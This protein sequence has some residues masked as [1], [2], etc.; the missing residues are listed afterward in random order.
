MNCSSGMIISK[1]PNTR[2]IEWDYQ[3][4]WRKKADALGMEAFLPVARW[5]A[6][7]ARSTTSA[8]LRAEHLRAAMAAST[9]EIM[10]F[11]TVHAPIIHPI[12]AA[13]MAATSI[14]S[15]AAGSG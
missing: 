1:V 10:T 6:P 5:E 13:K 8:E 3:L 7:A 12:V 15:P 14:T 2:R 11:A 4:G 9:R